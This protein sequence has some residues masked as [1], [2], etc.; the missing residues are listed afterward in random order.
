MSLLGRQKILGKRIPIELTV[1]PPGWQK[2]LGNGNPTEARAEESEG[3]F[4]GR[5]RC[6]GGNKNNSDFICSHTSLDESQEPKWTCC[7]V[8][9]LK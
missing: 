2:F 3:P 8:D 5:K 1:S 6:N 4:L 9:R 7:D